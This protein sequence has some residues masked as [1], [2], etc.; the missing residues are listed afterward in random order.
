M[1]WLGKLETHGES[2]G[3]DGGLPTRPGHSVSQT[4]EV[5]GAT[6]PGELEDL[7]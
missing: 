4:S 5:D 3:Y 7:D 2:L 6:A 1:Q